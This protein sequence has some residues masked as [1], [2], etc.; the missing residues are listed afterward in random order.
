MRI[1]THT[2]YLLFAD[3]IDPVAYVA[4]EIQ[5][6]AKDRRQAVNY[7]IYRKNGT[8]T[9]ASDTKITRTLIYCSA[10]GTKVNDVLI[11]EESA[12]QLLLELIPD[13]TSVYRTSRDAYGT[14]YSAREGFYGYRMNLT[15]QDV[16]KLA[17]FAVTSAIFRGAGYLDQDGNFRIHQRADT[18]VG[19][20]GDLVGSNKMQKPLFANISY[21]GIQPGYTINLGDVA[22]DKDGRRIMLGINTLVARLVYHKM[23]PE[24][25]LQEPLEQLHEIAKLT[26]GWTVA[27]SDSSEIS[28]TDVQRTFIEAA[29]KLGK[30]LTD[31]DRQTLGTWDSLLKNLDDH[32]DNLP[33]YVGWAEKRRLLQRATSALEPRMKAKGRLGREE[34][35]KMSDPRIRNILRRLDLR[36]HLVNT[37]SKIEALKRTEDEL[38]KR[39]EVVT[40]EEPRPEY[41]TTLDLEE[42]RYGEI[43]TPSL[44]EEA[45]ATSDD[46]LSRLDALDAMLGDIP[47]APKKE[48]KPP[49]R[50]TKK[51]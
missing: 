16:E 1:V 6:R 23:L 25:T 39:P 13:G 30:E 42:I 15:I 5:M 7:S 19:L 50:R 46:I 44:D 28:A 18:V 20:T 35:L 38:A 36:Y 27:Q 34:R 24:I 43:A 47:P 41:E 48:T 10:S 33:H 11:G 32:P 37:P 8:L 12:E 45:E 3:D 31:D 29:Y 14:T 2:E 49:A 4:N 9:F 21:G 26:S 22:M 17:A 51:A 40:I